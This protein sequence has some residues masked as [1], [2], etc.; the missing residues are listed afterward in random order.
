MRLTYFCPNCWRELNAQTRM[1]P[2]CGYDLAVYEQ[3]P[4][5]QKLL[6]AVSHPVQDNCIVAIQ[7]LGRMR[8]EA[9]VPVFAKVLRT[10]ESFYVIR[11]IARA[12]AQ[13][14]SVPGRELLEELCLHKL[15]MVRRL[16][17]ELLTQSVSV[18]DC[19]GET[20]P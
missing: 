1:C 13:I 15:P 9:A 2:Y 16:A 10:E 5:E 17:Q 6:R 19:E 11:E 3:L 7:S 14:G 20:Q 12:L 4:F 8:S 18:Q